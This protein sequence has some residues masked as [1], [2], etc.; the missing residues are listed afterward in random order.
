[1]KRRSI[2]ILGFGNVGRF[3]ADKILNDPII[4]QEFELAFVWNRSADKLNVL[5]ERYRLKGE[6]L[7]VA[8]K[9]YVN[10]NGA[11]DLVVELSHSVV[12][13]NFAEVILK[14]SDMLLTTLTALAERQTEKMLTSASENKSVY[15]ASGA[16][17]GVQDVAKLDKLGQVENLKVSMYFNADA[18]KLTGDLAQSLSEYLSTD[19]EE[20]L[21]LYKGDIRTLASMAPNNVNTMCCLAIAASSQ[22]LDNTIGNLYAK[23]KGDA[24]L[25]EIEVYGPDGFYVKT[26]RY[27]PAKKGAVTGDQTYY[28][29]LSSMQMA[30]GK[31]NGFH[32]C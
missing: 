31:E 8:F 20:P 7:G 14:H 18:L 9:E 22:G 10:K 2:G 1:M 5:E 19:N 12:I 27:N 26:Q 23:K 29:F 4:K 28:S 30:H 17:W 3:L 24:H 6:N 21:L 15:L 32:F 11:P 13:Q 25:V 16:A